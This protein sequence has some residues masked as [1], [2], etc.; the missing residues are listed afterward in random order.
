[1]AYGA[2]R[3]L[4]SGPL[5]FQRTAA[6]PARS[7]GPAIPRQ[8]VRRSNRGV[9]RRGL[10][11]DL[12]VSPTAV[13]RA[14]AGQPLA[15]RLLFSIIFGCILRVKGDSLL[16]R[17]DQRPQ[18]GA[19]APLASNSGKFP[20]ETN[21]HDAIGPSAHSFAQ[22]AAASIRKIRMRAKGWMDDRQTTRVLEKHLRSNSVCVD[23]GAHAGKILMQMRRFAPNAL[24]Y[25]FEPLPHLAA[26]LKQ[27]FPTTNILD[28]A[29][30][31]F[32]GTAEFKFVLNAPAYSG[33]RERAYDRADPVIQTIL[34]QVARLDDIIPQNVTVALI[35]L[36]IEGGEYHAML[37]A[38]ETI[39][40]SRPVIIFEASDKSSAYYSVSPAML[41]EIITQKFGLN[42]ST[43]KR[44][45]NNEGPLALAGFQAAYNATGYFIAYP[46][47]PA[48]SSAASLRSRNGIDESAQIMTKRPPTHGHGD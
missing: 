28:C 29:L 6:E 36:D 21:V 38:A 4:P 16:I 47:L 31:N 23:V 26:Q 9:L 12:L 19:G 13:A 48:R 8:P 41:Y 22:Q 30:S 25:A 3:V 37:G 7:L 5:A 39:I 34:V 1:M 11:L 42:L 32:S 15:H 27:R 46:G 17:A 14:V 10:Y 2:S 35:K 18:L 40:R 43:M 20:M 45:L 44:W 24:H 33:L